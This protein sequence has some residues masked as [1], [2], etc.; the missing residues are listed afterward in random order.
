[1]TVVWTCC[2]SVQL[3]TLSEFR[4]GAL[5]RVDCCIWIGLFLQ[6]AFFCILR[7]RP[8][9]HRCCFF[10]W[11]VLRVYFAYFLFAIPMCITL[12]LS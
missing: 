8:G 3:A 12:K 2:G 4:S 9:K 5:W 6:R 10:C 1:M 11:K 7:H